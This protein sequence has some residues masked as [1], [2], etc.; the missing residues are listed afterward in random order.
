MGLWYDFHF[1]MG[2]EQ[3]GNKQKIS[4]DEAQTVFIDHLAV[5]KPDELHS[6]IEEKMLIMGQTFKGRVVVVSYIKRGDKIRLINTRK[7]THN[8]RKQYEEHLFWKA[9]R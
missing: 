7:A 9:N 8:E 4:F 3:S 2:Y 1:W 5:I 6:D